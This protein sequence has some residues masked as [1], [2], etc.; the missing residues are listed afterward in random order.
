M[1]HRNPIF[2]KN[3]ISLTNFAWLFEQSDLWA[4][5]HFECCQTK[6]CIEILFFQKIGFLELGEKSNQISSRNLISLDVVKLKYGPII[7][8]PSNAITWRF[9]PEI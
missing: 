2:P 4:I 1:L 7:K 3:R 5:K 9:R 8:P 6:G